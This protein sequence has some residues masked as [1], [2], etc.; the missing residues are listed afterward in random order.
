MCNSTR[1]LIPRN[2]QNEVEEIL[3]N[4]FKMIDH[5]GDNTDTHIMGPLI[6]SAQ[7]KVLDYIEKGKAEGA[8]LLLGGGTPSHLDKG[9]FMLN[10]QFS[11]T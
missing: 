3:M 7:R 9:F 2:R 1:L 10:P 6:S 4:Y 5:G 8:R 11:L